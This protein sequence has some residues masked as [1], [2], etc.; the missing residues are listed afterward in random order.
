M[1]PLCLLLTPKALQKNK[2]KLINIALKTNAYFLR[3]VIFCVVV[4]WILA[5]SFGPNV[6]KTEM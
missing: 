6:N 1:S 2:Y 5:E 3:V 4:N